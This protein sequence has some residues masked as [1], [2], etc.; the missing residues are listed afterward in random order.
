MAVIHVCGLL[1][2][3]KTIWC[4]SRILETLIF[5]NKL[6]VT[7]IRFVDFWDKLFAQ[8]RMKGLVTFCRFLLSP[9]V[10]IVD[11][12]LF[13]AERVAHRYK[14]FND[15]S[16]AVQYSCGLPN[17]EENSRLFIWDE[18]HLDL[19]AREWKTTGKQMIEF[20]SM[21][22]KRGFDIIMVSQLQGAVD[23]QMRDLA[24]TSYKLKN[25][26]NFKPFG[27]RI[28]PRVGLLVK[29]WSN[30]AGSEGSGVVVGASLVRYSGLEST[31]YDTKQILSDKSLP[32]PL[33]W[34]A[35]VGR[36]SCCR[37]S[38]FK[39]YIKNY[40]F[41]SIYKPDRDY[42]GQFPNRLMSKDIGPFQVRDTK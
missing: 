11:Y 6:I 15:L 19:N 37:C 13:L 2:S 39:W 24:D 42:E 23:R 1:G 38:Y 4:V 30:K 16:S 14:Y 32:A 36:G 21:S 22:R 9:M 29:R 10:S 28:F 35:G 25:L 12:Q 20:F 27:V 31:L 8:Y 26:A 33:L 18:I 41:V 5:S 7:N 3:G 17:S 34:S 40:D